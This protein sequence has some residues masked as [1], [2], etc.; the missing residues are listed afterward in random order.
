VQPGVG[1]DGLVRAVGDV[2]EQHGGEWRDDRHCVAGAETQPDLAVVE[3][4]VGEGA[5]CDLDEWLGVEQDQQ[6]DYAVL[7]GRTKCEPARWTAGQHPDV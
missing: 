7:Q 3:F 1:G 6:R 4:E 5:P 2:V